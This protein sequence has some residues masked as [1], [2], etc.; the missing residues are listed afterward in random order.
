MGTT[1]RSLF[2]GA[3]TLLVC[4][5]A[6]ALAATAPGRRLFPVLDR[7][8]SSSAVALTFDDGPGA[9]TEAF[10][11]LLE[12]S[13]AIA[14]FFLVGERVERAPS[15]ALE[16]VRCG[17]EVGVHGY[18]H[19]N[20]LRL[21]PWQI[22]D[23]L[24]RARAVIEDVTGQPTR[25]FRPPYG[26]FTLTTWWEARRQGW[27]PVLWNRWGRDW[28]PHA[29]PASIAQRI[30]EPEAGDILLLHDSDAYS[31]P[32]SWRKTLAAL[33]LILEQLEAK[34]LTARSLSELLLD[35]GFRGRECVASPHAGQ[36]RSLPAVPEAGRQPASTRQ[37]EV[38]S[39]AC[40]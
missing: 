32:G 34:Q 1:E 11:R 24:R 37:R 29:T 21:L 27:R 16:I 26:V 40:W 7:I 22:V 14:T 10:V 15:L 2:L 33:P 38:D 36:R 3:A 9:P 28:E 8:L 25:F 5:A 19:R 18:R 17:H 20:H 12:Q 6:P 30:G 39:C 35:P 31:A 23:D 13:G 4:H